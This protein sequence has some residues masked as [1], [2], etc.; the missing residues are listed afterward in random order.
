M[1]RLVL[2]FL[3]VVAALKY[4][5]IRR[6]LRYFVR[7]N[8]F[9]RL[10]QLRFAGRDYV[11]RSPYKVIDYQ[12][13]FDQELRYVLP[14]AYWHHLN[15]TL[16]Q[17]ISCS[18]TKPFYFF[19]ENHLER[20]DKRIWEAGYDYYE[21][22]N[23]T[24]SPTFDFTKWARVPLRDQY[25]NDVFA[26]D[27]PLLVIANKYNIEWDKPPVNF[28]DIP[29][30]DRIV[31]MFKAT[32][33]IVYNRPLATQIVGDNSETMDLKEHQWLREHHPEVVQMNDLYEQHRDNVQ[34]FNH[35]Q[36]MVYANC[37]RFISMHGGTAALASYFGGI[38]LILSHP[39]GGLEH[40]FNEYA[41][42]FP[43]LSGATILHARNRDEVFQ[44][45]KT[46]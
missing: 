33:Q 45:L 18:N 17:T 4:P 41:T 13:E 1:Q 5:A 46:F 31:T 16:R 15:G 21:V 34:S 26:F 40:H 39:G 25:K 36:L 22:P 30:L 23:M 3:Y 24:H 27:K 8:Y 42:I 10:N 6:D 11:S 35:L 32:H 38:N 7:D 20:Y 19:S 43:A 9:C 2:K 29:A 14:F 12:G 44:H 37:N 28:L